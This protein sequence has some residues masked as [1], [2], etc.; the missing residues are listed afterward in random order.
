MLAMIRKE[1]AEKLVDYVRNGGFLL[2]TYYSG[3]ANE[4]DYMYLGGQPGPFRE[5]AG[6][7]VEE[8]DGIK[9]GSSNS[10]RFDDGFECSVDFMCDVIRPETAETVAVYLEDYYRN[11]PCVMR[12]QF[13]K[14]TCLYVGAKPSKEGVDHILDGIAK[15]LDIR[16]V[17]RTEG[18][19]RASRR[20]KYLFV[21][22]HGEAEEHVD[23]GKAMWNILEEREQSSLS[24]PANGYAILIEKS[25]I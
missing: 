23:L 25:E 6:L 17:L 10:I 16:P 19:A 13:G 5:A 3:Y 24:L 18:R 7:W 9:P 2:L 11:T 20:G 4:C 14:G 1:H 21:I 15:E 22:N 12:N 8:I